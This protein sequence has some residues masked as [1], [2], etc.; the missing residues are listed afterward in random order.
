[1]QVFIMNWFLGHD[2]IHNCNYCISLSTRRLVPSLEHMVWSC[3][4]E[5]WWV[6][7]L[8]IGGRSSWNSWQSLNQYKIG[9]LLRTVE[10]CFGKTAN[11]T[12]GKC[13]IFYDYVCRYHPTAYLYPIARA[14]GRSHQDIGVEGAIAVLMNLLH[15]LEF[16]MWRMRCG[17]NG[18]LE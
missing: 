15:H 18:I 10:T 1:M 9:N 8:C 11:Y 4:K 14:C 13:S 17:G 16:M 3:Y 5:A 2:L 12:K 6:S 7:C